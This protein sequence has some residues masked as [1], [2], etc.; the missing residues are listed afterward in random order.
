MTQVINKNLDEAK[1]EVLN[2][3]NDFSEVMGLI[4]QARRAQLAINSYTQDDIDELVTSIAWNVVKNREELAR[5]AVG[6]GGFGNYDDKVA[7]IYNRVTGTLADMQTIK[8]VGVVADYPNIG[9]SKI[10]K[11]IGFEP[12][13][14][15]IILKRADE[16]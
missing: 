9:I 13:L 14:A 5:M 7:K 4:D 12:L 10:A 6:E 1:S 2:F 16:V 8:T 11:P 3:K 15:E